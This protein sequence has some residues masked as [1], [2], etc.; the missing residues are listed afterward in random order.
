M[1]NHVTLLGYDIHC[2]T[3]TAWLQGYRDYF[4]C[5]NTWLSVYV[6]YELFT[7]QYIRLLCLF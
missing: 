6:N 4:D 7:K 1:A 2:F 5:C 3:V